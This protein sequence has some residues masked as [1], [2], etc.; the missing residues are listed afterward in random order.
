MKD[1]QINND[2]SDPKNSF[3]RLRLDKLSI[4][5]K[6]SSQKRLQTTKK[7]K[8]LAYS[9]QYTKYIN[10]GFSQIS[11]LMIRK[12]A[13]C[14]KIPIAFRNSSLLGKLESTVKELLMNELEITLFGIYLENFGWNCIEK[15]LEATLKYCGILAKKGLN[16]NIDIILNHFNLVDNS[17]SNT[18]EQ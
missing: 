6:L 5:N 17:F 18:Y 13:S 14:P 11:I 9:E 8:I 4:P 10:K 12:I 15:S 2:H 7:Q 16:Q 1:I 3:K